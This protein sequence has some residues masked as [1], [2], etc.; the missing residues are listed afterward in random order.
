MITYELLSQTLTYYL[1]I[2]TGLVGQKLII[3]TIPGIKN[4][5]DN[6]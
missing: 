2:V 3:V 1:F 6:D 5:A 4:S